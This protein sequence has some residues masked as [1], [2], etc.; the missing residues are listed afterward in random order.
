MQPLDR[1]AFRE[2][3]LARSGG[4]CVVCGRPAT[5]AHHLVERHLWPDG[6]YYLD[7]GVALC[8]ADHLRAEDTTLSVESL[9]ERAGIDRTL[10][11]P[12]FDPDVRIDKWGNTFTPEGF[13]LLGPMADHDGMK[14]IMRRAGVIIIG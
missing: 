14:R 10:V 6:G 9:R 13:R 12:G 2:G 5:A 3:V 7:N 11:P 8:D 4:R 1:T